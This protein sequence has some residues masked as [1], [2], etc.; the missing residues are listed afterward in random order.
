MRED[1][2]IEIPRQKRPE[3]S[4]TLDTPAAQQPEGVTYRGT[5][6]RSINSQQK[7]C[8]RGVMVRNIEKQIGE[9]H[10]A[11]LAMKEHDLVKRRQCTYECLI[12]FA[13]PRGRWIIAEHRGEL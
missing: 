1:R 12:H 9:N 10:R 13:G 4:G 5:L 8:I 3:E 6:E 11:R 2:P 7:S